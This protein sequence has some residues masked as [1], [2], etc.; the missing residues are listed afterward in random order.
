MTIQLIVGDDVNNFLAGSGGAAFLDGRG[1]DDQLFGGEGDDVLDGGAGNDILV[2]ASGNNTYLFGR[3]AGSDLIFEGDFKL[4]KH[5]VLMLGEDVAASDVLVQKQGLDLVLSIRD[6][7]DQVRVQG[8]FE[9]IAMPFASSGGGVETMAAS[10]MQV[11][12]IRF[13][14]GTRW[15]ALAVLERAQLDQS[16]LMQYDDGDNAIWTG[17]PA[18]GGGGNDLMH[19]AGDAVLLRGGSGNDELRVDFGSALMQGGSGDDQ[20]IGREGNDVLDG[21]SGNDLLDAGGGI[22][23]IVFGRGAGHDTLAAQ[24][25]D[26]STVNTVLLGA[27]ITPGALQVQLADHAGSADLDIHILGSDDVLTVAGFTQGAALALRFADGTLWDRAAI[28]EHALAPALPVVTGTDA[29]D[30]LMGGWDGGLLL[31]G[32]GDDVLGGGGGADVLVGGDGNDLLFGGGGDDTFD[33]GAGNDK[34]DPGTGNDVVLFGR[35]SGTDS[36]VNLAGGTLT[37]ALDAGI[38]PSDLSLTAGYDGTLV[39]HV[40]GSDATLLV[41][42]YL[43][44]WGAGMPTPTVSF[45]FADGSVWDGA[46]IGRQL[47]TGDDNPNEIR[48]T[49]GNDAV[50]GKGGDDM[51]F[52]LAGNDTLRGGD[53]NDLL[54]AGSG[55]DVLIGGRGNDFLHGEGGT[56]T[57]RFE[58]GDGWD[59]IL[60]DFLAG[61]DSASRIVFGAGVRPA[62][63][64][65]ALNGGGSYADL[66]LTYNGGADVIA[67]QNYLQ[68]GAHGIGTIEF[69]D[70]TV[71]DSQAIAALIGQGAP[72]Y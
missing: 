59:T 26:G 7:Q 68:A 37:I 3:G 17:G 12:E 42:Q 52:G 28:V 19:S 48:A 43:P 54:D 63:V 4:H 13:A 10:P 1:G 60:T 15:N 49:N 61:A 11:E 70:G 65:L 25:A 29:P 40:A 66:L 16:F 21:G 9:Q 45:A 53:G 46:V 39:A 57:Y 34:I 62:E 72:A 6:S 18:D 31:G 67:V 8:Y 50:D 30:Q 51:L 14:D 55:D 38:A 24:P 5:S 41:E 22:N 23:T 69:A 71:W 36:L 20:L 27:G 35:A 33:G 47:F 58:A 64:V 44:Q 32:G 56:D 2:G